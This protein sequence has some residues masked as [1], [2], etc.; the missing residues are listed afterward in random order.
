M[1]SIILIAIV[2]SMLV[3]GYTVKKQTKKI[4]KLEEI[5]GKGK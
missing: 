5:I 1:L 2:V 4:Q 3:I